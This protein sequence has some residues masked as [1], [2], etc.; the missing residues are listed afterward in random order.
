MWSI[1]AGGA[2]FLPKGQPTDRVPSLHF[3]DTIVQDHTDW[4]TILVVPGSPSKHR[5]DTPLQFQVAKIT[6]WDT[7][8]LSL[9]LKPI[10]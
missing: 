4:P 10:R 2:I 9:S 3:A 1:Q 6:R 7:H 8:H 5:S